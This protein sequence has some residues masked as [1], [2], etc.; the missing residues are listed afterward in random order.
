[1]LAVTG[2]AIGLGNIWKFPYITGENGGGAFVL[3]YLLAIAIIGIPI[4]MAEVML[5]RR[6]RRSPVNTLRILSREDG[7]SPLWVLLGYMGIC[8]GILIL[9]FYSVIAGWAIAYLF[10]TASGVFDGVTAD[11]VVTIFSGLISEPERLLA[12]HTIFL[13]I[14]MIVVANGV[15]S[16][17]Q[18][19]VTYLMPLL[20]LLLLILLWYSS[21]MGNSFSA[22]VKFL[23]YPDFSKL[24]TNVLYDLS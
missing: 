7:A 9:S 12:W 11:G 19:A 13:T 6:G 10:R 17:L 22:G 24:T 20:V 18:R 5:G 2:S 3:I 1:M 15:R 14:T 21:Q 4:M 16:G 8:A 23:I